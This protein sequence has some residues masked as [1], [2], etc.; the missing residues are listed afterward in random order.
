MG[1]ERDVHVLQRA[2]NKPQQAPEALAILRNTA[3]YGQCRDQLAQ[4]LN[5]DCLNLIMVLL[6]SN[7]PPLTLEDTSSLDNSSDRTQG[8]RLQPRIK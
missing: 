2:H 7:K 3:G 4:L 6:T 1:S 8:P 5:R